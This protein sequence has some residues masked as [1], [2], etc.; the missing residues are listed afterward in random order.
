MRCLYV[1]LTLASQFLL[2]FFHLLTL[3]LFSLR[4]FLQLHI[5]NILKIQMVT[6]VRL[7]CN[8]SPWNTNSGCLKDLLQKHFFLT[9]RKWKHVSQVWVGVI[10]L[11][12]VWL[13]LANQL[14]FCITV[15]GYMNL[16]DLSF[17]DRKKFIFHST[18]CQKNC[19]LGPPFFMI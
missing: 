13:F 4:G 15:T 3:Q 1:A 12:L 14:Y 8:K 7:T 6:Y 16:G 17:L 10:C 2:A 9:K 19:L 18:V 11:L 5:I